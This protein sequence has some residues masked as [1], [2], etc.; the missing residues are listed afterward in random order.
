VHS[1]LAWLL[2]RAELLALARG[3]AGLDLEV[4]TASGLDCRAV[5]DM[6]LT[7]AGMAVAVD[8]FAE[9]AGMAAVVVDTDQAD[10]LV[11]VVLSEM[12]GDRPL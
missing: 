8:T 6:R 7:V 2:Q 3:A 1:H 12:S 10:T 4:D 9:V 11:E 5:G